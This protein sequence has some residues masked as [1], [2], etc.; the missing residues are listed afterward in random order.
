MLII[1]SKDCSTKIPDWF[2]AAAVF[3][4]KKDLQRNIYIAYNR[5]QKV[6]NKAGNTIYSLEDPYS[7]FK[8]VANT[9][10]Y[11]KQGKMEM[12]ARLDNLGPFHV[13]FTISCFKL[14]GPGTIM[15]FS[16]WILENRAEG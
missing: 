9:P 6:L 3:K 12:V 13:F 1:L 16:G 8:S 2:F 7:V 14:V 15:E 10:A 11:H 5:G 4:E